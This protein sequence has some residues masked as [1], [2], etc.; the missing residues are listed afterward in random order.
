[1][2]KIAIFGL[3]ISASTLSSPAIFA[4]IKSPESAPVEQTKKVSQSS[5][6]GVWIEAVPMALGQHLSTHLKENQGVLIRE[7]TA[8][9]PASKAG[10]QAFDVIVKVNEQEI[11]TRD[12]LTRLIRSTP[13]KTSVKLTLIRQG[14]LITQ[15]VIL[16]PAPVEKQVS[17]GHRMPHGMLPHYFPKYHRKGMNNMP[18]VFD[19]P[20]FKQRPDPFKHM[21]PPPSG[22]QQ[23]SWSQFESIQIESTGDDK[24]KAKVKHKDSKGNKTRI[25][26]AG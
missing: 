22:G 7:V 10:I 8:D 3:L 5:W 1:M 17:Q 9:S 13:A 2:K 4:D 15:D 19:H 12:Q 18:P 11:F 25:Y 23:S 21:P 24:H 16:E 6:L 20:F 14:Q 26:R